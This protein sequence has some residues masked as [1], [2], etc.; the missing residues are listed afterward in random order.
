MKLI[1]HIGSGKTG[2]TS[3]QAAFHNNQEELRSLKISYPPGETKDHNI[4]EASVLEFDNLHRVYRSMYSGNRDM[5]KTIAMNLIKKIKSTKS[6]YVILSGEYFFALS[7]SKAKA[8][9]DVLEI[10]PEDVKVVCYVRNPSS[11]WLSGVQQYLKGSWNLEGIIAA[12]YKF[13]N[14][15]TNWGNT[16]GFENVIVRQFD[17]S[18]LVGNDIVTDFCHVISEIT[19]CE[20]SIPSSGTKNVSVYSEQCILMQELRKELLLVPENTFNTE[21]R[22]LNRQIHVSSK[23]LN[24]TKMKFR[25]EVVQYIEHLHSEDMQW[26]KEK[27]KLDISLDIEI[28]EKSIEAGKDIVISNKIKTMLQ[29]YNKEALLELESRVRAALLS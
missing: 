27:F 8:L 3:V 21:T 17:K 16:V 6:D 24:L 12:G 7:F 18:K 22:K 5:P 4:L 2:T 14:G 9:L 20:I 10:R 26:L 25:P 28:D 15:L 29:D 23:N 19:N 13:K 11:Y 1:L